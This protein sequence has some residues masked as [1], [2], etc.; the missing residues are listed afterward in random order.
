MAGAGQFRR[1]RDHLDHAAGRDRRAPPRWTTAAHIGG[2]LAGAVCGL[3]LLCSWPASATP[4]A[5]S[6]RRTGHRRGRN[7][8]GLHRARWRSP[9]ATPPTSRSRHGF[10][11]TGCRR[12]LPTCNC[13]GRSLP[14]ATRRIRAP[15]C[16]TASRWPARM[17]M[18]RPSSEFETSL[19][20]SRRPGR[21]HLRTG[22]STTPCG[23]C[24]PWWRPVRANGHVPGTSRRPACQA[25]G[26]DRPPA[27]LTQ[28]L[29]RARLCG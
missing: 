5:V 11:R 26:T 15:T 18:P 22:G 25:R 16:F 2:A 13:T 4:A 28:L 23:A 20:R 12:P 29:W 14:R 17:T 9:R 10:R 8:A 3:V 19:Q 7:D 1:H 27:E 6:I 21:R 24:S